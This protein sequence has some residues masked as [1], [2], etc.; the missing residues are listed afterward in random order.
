MIK[1][2]QGPYG[3]FLEMETTNP[4]QGASR[5]ALPPELLVDSELSLEA[6]VQLLQWP[7]VGWWVARPKSLLF[8]DIGAS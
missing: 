4:E 8:C 6:A 1:L 5:A 3:P 7:K 2:K